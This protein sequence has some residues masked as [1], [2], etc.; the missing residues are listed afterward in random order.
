VRLI[1]AFGGYYRIFEAFVKR[2]FELKEVNQGRLKKRGIRSADSL[3]RAS[4]I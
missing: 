4:F 1:T 2:A 3:V